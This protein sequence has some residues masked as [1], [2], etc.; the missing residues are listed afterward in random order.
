MQSVKLTELPNTITR[1]Y[2]RNTRN[3]CCSGVPTPLAGVRG[4]E[5]GC[6]GW[7]R[8]GLSSVRSGATA[9]YAYFYVWLLAARVT[10]NSVF[11]DD[12]LRLTDEMLCNPP[13]CISWWDTY[14]SFWD[15]VAFVIHTTGF[16]DRYVFRFVQTI[17]GRN[18][19]PGYTIEALAWRLLFSGWWQFVSFTEKTRTS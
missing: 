19:F 2:K 9:D 4:G 1:C 11:D 17:Y 6:A 15:C 16:R 12:S 8:Q 3:K 13:R 14:L 18:L 7:R 10:Y 5:R